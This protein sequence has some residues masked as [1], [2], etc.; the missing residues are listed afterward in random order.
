M[1][2]QEKVSHMIALN[3]EIEHLKTMIR[4]HDTGHIY[5]TISTLEER[6]K[7]LHKEIYNKE[8]RSEYA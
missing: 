8:S 4:P 5:T 6:V 1:T 3:T 7:T 2:N